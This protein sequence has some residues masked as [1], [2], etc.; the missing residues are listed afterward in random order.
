[1]EAFLNSYLPWGIFAVTIIICFYINIIDIGKRRESTDP[2]EHTNSRRL[3]FHLI[4]GTVIGYLVC[5]AGLPLPIPWGAAIGSVCGLVF[6]LWKRK[7]R[8]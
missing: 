7:H 5:Y 2:Y 6:G 1:M 8:K 4:I 3:E